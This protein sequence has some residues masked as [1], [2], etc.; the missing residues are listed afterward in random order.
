MTREKTLRT[1]ISQTSEWESE[2]EIEEK[3]EKSANKNLLTRVNAKIYK[4]KLESKEEIEFLTC[5]S[6][7]LVV[8][9]YLVSVLL[10][11][12]LIESSNAKRVFVHWLVRWCSL[13][14]CYKWLPLSVLKEKK[15]WDRARTTSSMCVRSMYVRQWNDRM[16]L[17]SS[18]VAK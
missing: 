6:F 5:L 11:M 12:N 3:R 7:F 1:A 16:V 18:M 15:V 13:S 9:S 4:N 14:A 2:R 17:V 8:L 10:F